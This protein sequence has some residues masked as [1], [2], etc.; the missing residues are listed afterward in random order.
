LCDHPRLSVNTVGAFQEIV[1]PCHAAAD[2]DTPGFD[3]FLK[4]AVRA[5]LAV[6]SPDG[7]SQNDDA[8]P[9]LR[10]SG[11]P[12]SLDKA[13]ARKRKQAESDQNSNE[14]QLTSDS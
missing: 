2:L 12:S 13:L 9:F 3:A 10:L 7:S 1:I 8:S 4:T 6:A 5:Y 11:R 14:T